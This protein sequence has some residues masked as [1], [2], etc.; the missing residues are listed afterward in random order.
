MLAL[1]LSRWESQKKRAVSDIREL[2]YQL[3]GIT[4]VKHYHCRWSALFRFLPVFRYILCYSLSPGCWSIQAKTLYHIY[5]SVVWFNRFMPVIE[6]RRKAI[7]TTPE[8]FWVFLPPYLHCSEEKATSYEQYICRW[9]AVV[10]YFFFNCKYLFY[11]CLLQCNH[12]NVVWIK[13]NFVVDT[14][15][16]SFREDHYWILS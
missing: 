12:D 13:L 7:S 2:I 5:S 3:R 15:R 8:L 1:C 4:F 11:N 14:Y 16:I 9:V 6:S 10:L